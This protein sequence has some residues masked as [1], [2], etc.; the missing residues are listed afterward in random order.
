MPKE[1][2]EFTDILTKQTYRIEHHQ[3]KQYQMYRSRVV[4]GLSMIILFFQFNVS[5]PLSIGTGVLFIAISEFRYRTHF[6]K[7]CKILKQP[8]TKKE[9]MGQSSLIFN[10]ILYL[11]LG[12]ALI[13]Y[14]L[15]TSTIKNPIILFGIAGCSLFISI[16]YGIKVLSTS[17]HK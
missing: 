1:T 9:E 4:I 14:T 7:Q 12:C 2:I 13:F 3:L 10:M 5:L 15:S 8:T 6:L 17:K 11:V 16:V